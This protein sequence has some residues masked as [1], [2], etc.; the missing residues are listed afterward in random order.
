M[1]FLKKEVKKN[2]IFGHTSLLSGGMGDISHISLCEDE[3][4]YHFDMSCDINE[5]KKKIIFKNCA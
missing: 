3:V 1:A 2:A 5:N 4:Y